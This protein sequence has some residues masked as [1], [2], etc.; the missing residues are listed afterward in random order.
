MDSISVGRRWVT[1]PPGWRWLPPGERWLTGSFRK[2][3]SSRLELSPRLKR[4]QSVRLTCADRRLAVIIAGHGQPTWA[5]LPK[6]RVSISLI[7]PDNPALHSLTLTG[8]WWHMWDSAY[9]FVNTHTHTQVC[10][11]ISKTH[12]CRS[13]YNMTTTPIILFTVSL[14][15]SFSPHALALHTRTHLTQWWCSRLPLAQ[16]RAQSQRWMCR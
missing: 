10:M 15:L 1:H 16:S 7:R 4:W 12:T 9:I 14:A 8:R 2:C 3:A 13:K 11:C 5:W 6:L